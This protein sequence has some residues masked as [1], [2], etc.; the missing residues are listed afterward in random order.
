MRAIAPSVTIWAAD[1]HVAE[2]L[3]FD[4][5]EAGAAAAFALALRGIETERAGIQATL[6]RRFGLRKE[7]PDVLER[8]DVNGGIRARRFAEG[9]LIHQYDAAQMFDARE[10]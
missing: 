1:E 5:L 3:H 7:F 8:A 6:L 10:A 4:F 9:G 2:K